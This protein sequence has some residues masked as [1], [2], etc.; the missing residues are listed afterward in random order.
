MVGDKRQVRDIKEQGVVLLRAAHRQDPRTDAYVAGWREA[1]LEV[2]TQQEA[3][4]KRDRAAFERFK[5][6]TDCLMPHDLCAPE[7]FDLKAR[8]TPRRSPTR[9]CPTGRGSAGTCPETKSGEGPERHSVR[10]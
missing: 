4:L 7:L 2:L 5:H 3:L 9:C 6:S 8:A 1:V 10:P